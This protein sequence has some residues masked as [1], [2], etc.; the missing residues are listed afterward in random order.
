M[1]TLSRW[2]HVHVMLCTHCACGA[3]YWWY[4]VHVVHMVP[5]YVWYCVHVINVV[6]WAYRIMYMHH[7]V[8][9]LQRV[10]SLCCTLCR[11]MYWVVLHLRYRWM[12]CIVY[13]RCRCMC[14]MS[15]VDA[16]IAWCGMSCGFM[17]VLHTMCLCTW[18]RRRH[19]VFVG[20][21]N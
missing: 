18:L 19:S 1:Y 13:T 6:L 12:H 4:C 17:C 15:G 9:T 16:C 14:C 10:Y 7:V 3:V 8:M 5:M 20:C 11:Y 2:C 21:S